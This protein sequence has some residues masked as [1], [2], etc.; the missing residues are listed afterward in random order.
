MFE[1]KKNF[2]GLSYIT[3]NSKINPDTSVLDLT[4]ESSFSNPPEELLNNV[5][6]ALKYGDKSYDI[7]GYYPL[8]EIISDIFF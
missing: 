4:G 8:R 1:L 6:E 5:L 3:A 2:P 7:D